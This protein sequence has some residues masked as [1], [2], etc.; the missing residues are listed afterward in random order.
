MSAEFLPVC[1]AA[2]DLDQLDGRLV[3]RGG[4]AGEAAPVGVGLLGDDLALFDEP[5]EDARDVEAV[6]AALEAEGQ[7]L[8]VDEDGQGTFA[9]TAVV[10]HKSIPK[11]RF[12]YTSL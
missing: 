5:F 7:V 11:G 10:F 6:A 9:V 1:A 8:E 4:V 2:R 3:Q 12:R